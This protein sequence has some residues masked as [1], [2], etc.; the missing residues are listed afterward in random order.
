MKFA[1]KVWHW[2]NLHLV[3][4][5]VKNA[6]E[7]TWVYGLWMPRINNHLKITQ[8]QTKIE[9][10]ITSSHLPKFFSISQWAPWR[11]DRSVGW[12]LRCRAWR[13]PCRREPS[14]HRSQRGWLRCRGGATCSRRG[15]R[16]GS[17]R[18]PAGSWCS[19]LAGT[20]PGRQWKLLGSGTVFTPLHF[21]CSTWMGLIS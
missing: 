9:T 6:P 18:E 21:L 7:L 5:S 16:E 14:K 12:R 1:K 15:W 8:K 11:P 20:H 10:K 13:R 2:R 4:K 3:G 17:I 19:M